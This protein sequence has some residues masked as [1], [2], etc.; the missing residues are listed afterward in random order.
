LINETLFLTFYVKKACE[1]SPECNFYSYYDDFSFCN[2]YNSCTLGDCGGNARCRSYA[3]SCTPEPEICGAAAMCS[4]QEGEIEAVKSN[5]ET[6][7]EC[8]RVS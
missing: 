2:L 6:L 4:G 5:V 7:E 8:Q 1:E 3:A